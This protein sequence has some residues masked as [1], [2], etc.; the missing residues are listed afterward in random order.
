MVAG[1]RC[2]QEHVALREDVATQ[3]YAGYIRK[4]GLSGG[5]RHACISPPIYMYSLF[6]PW[7]TFQ[8]HALIGGFRSRPPMIIRRAPRPQT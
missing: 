3:K 7:S 2:N 5:G 8:L 1:K 6:A 4:E